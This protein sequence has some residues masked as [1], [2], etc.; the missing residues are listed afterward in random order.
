M[1]AARQAPQLVGFFTESAGLAPLA[2]LAAQPIAT[3]C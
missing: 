1:L 3:L 2:T